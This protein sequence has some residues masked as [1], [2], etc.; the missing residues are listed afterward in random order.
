[1]AAAVIQVCVGVHEL[2]IW[3]ITFFIKYTA[4]LSSC[5]SVEEGKLII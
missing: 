4:T 2:A 3:L 1:M 5:K